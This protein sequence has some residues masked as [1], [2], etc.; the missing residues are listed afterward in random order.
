MAQ[1]M[2]ELDGAMVSDDEGEAVVGKAQIISLPQSPILAQHVSPSA[3]T[4]LKIEPMSPG[5]HSY[6]LQNGLGME[7]NR[8]DADVPDTVSLRTTRSARSIRSFRSTRSARS[9]RSMRF[10]EPNR[11]GSVTAAK[12]RSHRT[13]KSS[14]RLP[15]RKPSLRAQTPHSEEQPPMP[16][17]PIEFIPSMPPISFAN[18]SS[19]FLHF[20]S[21]NASTIGL[22]PRRTS[23]DDIQMMARPPM[24]S[25]FSYSTVDDINVRPQSTIDD[26]QVVPRTPVP[27]PLPHTLAN[28]TAVDTIDLRDSGGEYR[29]HIQCIQPIATL[30]LQI[31]LYRISLLSGSMRMCPESPPSVSSP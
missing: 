10:V 3:G 6:P 31:T 9:S 11:L 14:L 18:P 30:S 22:G 15:N 4:I 29:P 28:N 8:A 7:S 16:D 27:V 13:S 12:T 24:Y 23:L 2:D 17:L 21:R 5:P 25:R 26:I 20:N 19:S 1:E